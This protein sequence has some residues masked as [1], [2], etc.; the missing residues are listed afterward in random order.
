MYKL[1]VVNLSFRW[2]M[3][4]VSKDK[5]IVLMS[6]NVCDRTKKHACAVFISMLNVMQM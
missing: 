3:F 1:R 2:W 6:V 4:T 5:S